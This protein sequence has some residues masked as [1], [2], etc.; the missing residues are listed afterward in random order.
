MEDHRQASENNIPLAIRPRQY[1]S[2]FPANAGLVRLSRS[3]SQALTRDWRTNKY[4]FFAVILSLLTTIVVVTYY[5]NHPQP[6]PYPDTETYLTFAR[7]I[8]TQGRLVDA[9][10]VPGFPLLIVLVFA[11]AGQG[12]LLAVS[13]VHAALFILATIELYLLTVLVFQRGWVALLIALLVGTNLLLLSFI[14]PLVTEALSLWLLI[15][16]ALAA[17]LFVYTLRI[18]YMWLVTG[19]TLALFLTRAEWIYAPV[20][21]FAYLLLVAVWRKAGRRLLDHILVSVLLLYAIMGC[22]VYINA[23]QNNFVGVTDTQN[24]NLWG[25]I[26]QY[27][28]Q[29]EA[30]PQ[31]AAVRQTVDVYLAHGVNDPRYIL[32]NEPSLE[33]NHY[34]LAGAYAQTIIEQHPVEFLAKSVPLALS[35]LPYFYYASQVA[36]GGSFGT[37]LAWL[38]SVSSSLYGWNAFFP[39]CAAFWFLML[40]WPR[41]ACLRSVQAMGAIV[42]LTLYGLIITS[43]GGYQEYTRYHTPFNPLLIFVVWGTLLAGS[44]LVVQQGPSVIAQL[45]NRYSHRKCI[46]ISTGSILVALISG[47]GAFLFTIGFILTHDISNQIGIVFTLLICILSVFRYF[48]FGEQR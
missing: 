43:L 22:Y 30:P 35:S 12:N 31:Y 29:D 16:L 9:H 7:Q 25:K 14:K 46:R 10:R 20:P 21:I 37:P 6:E 11:F 15:S 19:L 36:L 23:T 17:V 44:L 1:R 27:H 5:L 4:A 39:L 41:T 18:R 45:V 24:I 42:L 48:R 3:I 40:C 28:M 33:R 8:Q 2:A 47:I 26:I 34:A 32:D 38:Q 13:I